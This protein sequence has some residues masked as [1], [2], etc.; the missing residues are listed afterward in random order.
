MT[1]LKDRLI[2]QIKA[3]GPITISDY[4][5]QCLLDPVMGYYPTR[6]PL[7]SDGDFIT[8]PEISQMFG[9][10]LGLWAIQSW[11]DMGAPASIQLIELGPGRGIMMSD[12]LRTARLDTAFFNALSVTLIEAS[13]ALEAVQ[14]RTL[15]NCG[16]PITWADDLFRIPAGPSLIIGNEFLDCLPIRQFIQT[17][18]FAGRAGWKERMIMLDDNGRLA[19]GISPEPASKAVQALLPEG[20]SSARLDD[21]LEVC[22]AHALIMDAIGHR[23]NNA[24]GRALFIDYGPHITDFGDSL[25]ALKQHKKTGVFAAPGDCDL[26]ARVDFNALIDTAKAAELRV[27]GPVTQRALLSK[28]GIEMRAVALTKSHPDGKSKI[29]RQLH[30]LMDEEEM[31]S[32][33]KAVCFG[34]TDMESALG[35]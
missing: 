9:E 18:P 21:L 32:L 8:A 6:D 23:F 20:Q 30:R 19:F 5:A 12:I 31:G 13:A 35:F 28:L 24:A 11:R 26:T 14:G 17:D 22:P 25:Q 7:G 2:R 15:A 33:F 29:L 34:S 1:P 10:V 16:A 27:L 3:E 4:M